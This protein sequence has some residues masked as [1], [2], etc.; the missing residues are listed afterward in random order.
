M[1]LFMAVPMTPS[2]AMS[3][4]DGRRYRRF[5]TI[6]GSSPPPWRPCSCHRH[7]FM[8]KNLKSK[9][10][11]QTPFKYRSETNSIRLQLFKIE[12]KMN[13]V[14]SL[15]DRKRNE[16][17]VPELLKIEA[18]TSRLFQNFGGI[19]WSEGNYPNTFKVEGK[20][21]CCFLKIWENETEQSK[22]F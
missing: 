5:S 18:K 20:M 7:W 11:C 2:A 12:A 21:D 16:L 6:L 19:K 3:D 22:T 8:K 9:I 4:I 1:Q 15:K 14:R 10:S 17:L 13:L